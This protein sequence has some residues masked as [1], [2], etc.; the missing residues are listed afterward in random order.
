MTDNN[1]TPVSILGVDYLHIHIPNEG[2]LYVTEYGRRYL[3]NLKP[4][5][6]YENDWFQTHREPLAGTSTIYK[7]PTKTVNGVSKLLVVKWCRVGEQV[8]LDTFTLNKFAGGEFNSPYE[9]FALVKEMRNDR[10]KPAIYTHKPL[11]IYVPLKKLQLWQTGR[12]H[13]RMA[14]KKAKYRDVELD[15][16]RQYIL[17]YEWVKGISAVEACTT[18]ACAGHT[19]QEF[20]H[21][22]TERAIKEL[23]HKGFRVLDMKP[24]HIILRPNAQGTKFAERHGQLVYALVD[25]ELLERTPEHELAVAASRRA[26]YLT[27][28]RDRFTAKTK[29][30]FPAHLKPMTVYN[31]DYVYGHSESTQ[32]SLWVVGHDPSLFDFFQ[33]ERWRRTPKT[34][35]SP[36]YE[37]YYTKT[38][39]NIHLV[40]KVSRVGEPPDP[41]TNN[42][43]SLPIIQFGYNSPFE[44]FTIALDLFRRGFPVSYPRAIY[45]SGLETEDTAYSADQSRYLSHEPIKTPDGLPVLRH[46]HIYITVWGY[47]NGADEQLAAK[48]GDY[49]VSINMDEGLERGLIKPMDYAYLIR[50]VEDQLAALGYED[51]DLQGFHFLLSLTPQN[52]LLVDGDGFPVIRLWD[53]SLIRKKASGPDNR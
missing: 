5:N 39:D 21:E 24:E 16:Y 7:L 42:P 9:E 31:V 20:L 45:M 34:K 50:R 17:I 37:V 48:D 8:P 47:W 22:L 2:D 11:A 19:S 4:E 15:I 36:N 44:E 29:Y 23:A 6:W 46:N 40:W 33:P 49:C 43:K 25:F 3:E 26:D 12:S 14:Q 10:A 53:F 27:R 13:S 30:T 1:N 28:Q 51:L 52:R 32:G 35:I 38:K 18:P 41:E